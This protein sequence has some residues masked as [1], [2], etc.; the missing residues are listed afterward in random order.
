MTLREVEIET[1]KES[2]QNKYK[3]VKC[4]CVLIHSFIIF[5]SSNNLQ[6]EHKVVHIFEI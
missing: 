3:D 1:E 6:K 4:V 5:V 2:L